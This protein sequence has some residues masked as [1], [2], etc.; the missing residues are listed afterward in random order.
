M[1]L[2]MLLPVLV[3]AACAAASPLNAQGLNAQGP[4]SLEKARELALARSATLRKALL[5]VDSAL[6]AEKIQGYEYLPE[7]SAT[8]GAGVSSPYSK[9]PD[10]L[11]LS[12][13]ISVS[14]TLFAGGKRLLLAAIDSLGT[15][16]ARE[17]AR[18]EYLGVVNKVESAYYGLAQAQA[19]LEAAQKDLEAAQT[20]LKL[21][22]AKLEAKMIAPYAYLETESSA[23][24]K[25]TALIQAQGKLAVAEATLAS[26]TGL[27]APLGK[28]EVDFESHAGLIQKA[29]GLTTEETAQFIWSVREAAVKNNP[30]LSKKSLESEK[31]NKSVNLAAADYFPS[32]SAGFS[33][34][35]SGETGGGFDAGT[36]SISLTLSIPIKPWTVK[37]EVDSEKIA[38]RQADLDGEES[39]RTLELDV[40]SAA[41]DCIF[42]ARSTVSSE[43]ALEYAEGNYRSVLELYRLSAASSSDLMD[44]EALVSAN[45]AALI[46]ARYSF[47]VNLSTLRSLSADE[48]E[49]LLT[50]RIP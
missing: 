26:L 42:S 45:R 24:A 37:A 40:Q 48:N 50:G 43:K 38:S 39:L 6:L 11:A 18:E 35:L 20:H 7:I 3:L 27:R 15:R 13:G 31:S 2:R 28:V 29:A 12:A 41:Y 9:L 23:S 36:G 49:S 34:T 22:G 25:R 32:V 46:D 16:I 44:A 8:A 19:S 21:A 4:L 17:E 30:S 10:S 33:H 1:R 47:L 5:S 14:Q